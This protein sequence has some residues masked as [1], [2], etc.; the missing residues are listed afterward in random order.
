[1]QRKSIRL[2]QL[3]QRTAVERIAL[4]KG[5]LAFQ[6]RQHS[7]PPLAPSWFYKQRWHTEAAV[8]QQAAGLQA[9]VLV[10]KLKN[11]LNKH[12][13]PDERRQVHRRTARWPRQHVVR[14]CVIAGCV[15]RQEHLKKRS[16]RVRTRRTAEPAAVSPPLRLARRNRLQPAQRTDKAAGKRRALRQ[17]AHTRRPGARCSQRSTA[18]WT[19]ASR[20]GAAQTQAGDEVALRASRPP[21]CRRQKLRAQAWT[22]ANTHCVT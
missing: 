14:V 9:R 3:S 10:A 20:R 15:R 2:K 8:V 19:S 18:A 21:P 6:A 16:R 11:K 17:A 12:T 22:D 5:C 7:W 1:M 13:I 4:Q